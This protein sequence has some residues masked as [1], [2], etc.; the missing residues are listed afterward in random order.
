MFKV[1]K[2]EFPTT[3]TLIGMG[4]MIR[5]RMATDP[6]FKELYGPTVV[7][8]DLLPDSVAIAMVEAR[9]VEIKKNG[10]QHYYLDGIPRNPA[11]FFHFLDSDHINAGDT[12]VIHLTASDAV[13]KER[14]NH[15]NKHKP[16]GERLD[17]D[18]F[19]YRNDVYKRDLN[20]MLRIC[21]QRKMH[22]AE[23]DTENGLDKAAPIVLSFAHEFFNRRSGARSGV[24]FERPV[25]LM[26]SRQRIV[27]ANMAAMQNA[28]V[29]SL[30]G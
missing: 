3:L 25:E 10:H 2:R 6:E 24:R 11:Q 5:G 27:A 16:D 18:N 7:K 12:L 8:G 13:L 26:T 15:R 29:S 4:D 9:I 14:F 30:R 1:L 22:I 23:I 17:T 20:T 19:D 21:R 28:T